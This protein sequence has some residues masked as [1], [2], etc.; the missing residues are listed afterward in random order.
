MTR[1]AALD[2]ES[3]L[4][5]QVDVVQVA[6]ISDIH[7]TECGDPRTNV[8]ASESDA[9]ANALIGARGLLARVFPEADLLLCP[10]DL[11][12][13]GDTSPA[14]WV[15]ERLAEI[16]GDLGALRI[17]ATGNH[18]LAREPPP[19]QAPNTALKRLRP[20]FPVAD[21]AQFNSYWTNDFGIVEGAAW[22][23]ISM[24]TCGLHPY[25]WDEREHGSFQPETLGELEAALNALGEGP[26]VNI[27]M[28][29]H[30]PVEWTHGA[31]REAGHLLRGDRLIE[32]LAG[33][34]ERWILVNGHKHHS[35]LGYLGDSSNGPIWVSAG[36]IGADLLGDTGTTVRN[37]MHVVD[38]LTDAP[39]AVALRTAG[40][41]Y[42]FDWEPGRGW[43]E[44]TLRSGLPAR[45]A[46][47]YRRDS[48][49][50]VE[51]LRAELSRRSRTSIL[52]LDVLT[53]DP[54]WHFLTP[55][56]RTAVFEAVR[57]AG[58]GVAGN[59]DQPS[60]LEITLT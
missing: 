33:R 56:D 7:A 19:G 4:R 5:N 12:H 41:V 42:S 11:V 13:K 2:F 57:A 23:V 10:G 51:E 18:D 1:G 26:A 16:A 30:H 29:H 21:T 44:A 49:D 35:R 37:Q 45:C 54:R 8:A 20:R 50:L 38:V 40:E 60:T 47:G 9:D 53:W 46:F 27:C 32:L 52:W 14:A 55:A 58:G 43:E 31:E 3:P 48:W 24:N 17:G 22:R 36:S 25:A 15:W 59:P 28:V 34:P 6:V 39:S